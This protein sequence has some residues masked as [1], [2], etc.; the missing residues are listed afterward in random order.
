MVVFVADEDSFAGPSHSMLD[1]VLF[2]ALEACENWGV[3]FRLGFLG[4]KGVVREG[5]EAD[6]FGLIA[7]EGFGE[8]WRIGGLQCGGCN[9]GHLVCGSQVASWTV[10]W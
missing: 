7:I 1:I 4:A 3:F 9:G 10:G 2:E 8:D 5:V 6:C